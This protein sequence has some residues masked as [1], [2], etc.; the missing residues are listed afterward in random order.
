MVQKFFKNKKILIVF[1]VGGKS[2][3]IFGPNSANLQFFFKNKLNRNSPFQ[4]TSYD[5]L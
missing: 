4:D 2:K 3:H 5:I 1:G